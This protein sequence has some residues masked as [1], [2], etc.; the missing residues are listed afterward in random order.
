MC[1]WAGNTVHWG[2]ACSLARPADEDED[3]ASERAPDSPSRVRER[4][5]PSAEAFDNPFEGSD[6]VADGFVRVRDARGFASSD[7]RAPPRRARPR[8]SLACT[9]RRRS[10]S[11]AFK[12][13]GKCHAPFLTRAE[14]RALDVAGRARM[15][16]QSLALYSRWFETP[17]FL[18]GLL[19]EPGQGFE[20]SKEGGETFG[21]KT[22][23]RS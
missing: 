5:N 8:R 16:C 11:V 21:A 2:G 12:S 10:S 17:A 20:V 18:P 19:S 3:E 22:T 23:F 13:A 6:P 9:F 7:P 15:I 1:L 14:C 4:P